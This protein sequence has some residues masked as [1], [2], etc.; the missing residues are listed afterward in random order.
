MTSLSKEHNLSFKKDIK[1]NNAKENS[2]RAKAEMTRIQNKV[3]SLEDKIKIKKERRK[4]YGWFSKQRAEID[5][6]I[7][8]L[9]RERKDLKNK[10]SKLKREKVFK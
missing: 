10:A 2:D 3:Y 8:G 1:A 7:E 4:T 5:L 9:D 6:E